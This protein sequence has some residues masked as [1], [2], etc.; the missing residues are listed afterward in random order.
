MGWTGCNDW[1]TAND[2]R[3]DILRDHRREG[4]VVD[5]ASTQFGRHL[6]VAWT[7]DRAP[8]LPD[9]GRTVYLTLYLI[10]VDRDGGRY[11]PID[12]SMGPYYYDVPARLLRVSTPTNPGWR[13][14]CAR[15]RSGGR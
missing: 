8:L 6:W 14:T 5:S 9:G 1:R 12:E 7:N 11:K 2:V 13:E 3:D 10:E 4:E 15:L